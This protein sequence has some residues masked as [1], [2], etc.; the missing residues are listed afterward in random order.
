MP[1]EETVPIHLE[2]DG[3]ELD[4]MLNIFVQDE[5][6]TQEE[7]DVIRQQVID[8]VGQQVSILDF[9][10]PSWSAY[11]LTQEQMD[12]DGWFPPAEGE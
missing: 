2:A 4:Y 8:S 11:V 9:V 6:L 1:E 12:A 7:A 10:P 3:A 5:A